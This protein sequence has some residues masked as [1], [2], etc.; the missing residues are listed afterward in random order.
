MQRTPQVVLIASTLVACWLGMQLVHEL[1]HVVAA[2]LSGAQIEYL[3]LH[4]LEISRTDVLHNR[5]PLLVTWAGPICGVLFPM[6]LWQ[7]SVLL[8]RPTT[9]VWRFFTGFCWVAN[10]AYIGLGSFEQVGDCGELLRHGSPMFTLWLFGLVCV[11]VGLWIWHGQGAAFGMGAAQGVVSSGIAY[12]VLVV[13]IVL[14]VLGCVVA[15]LQKPKRSASQESREMGYRA[16]Q[17]P[18]TNKF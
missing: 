6:L 5:H 8:R 3:A 4:P 17:P 7:M 11:P 1:G 10:G 9:F 18:S 14:M 13:A 2:W 16:V 12:C 15:A